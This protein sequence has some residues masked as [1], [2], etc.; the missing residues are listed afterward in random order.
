MNLTKGLKDLLFYIIGFGLILYIVIV[1]SKIDILYY[2]LLI[3]GLFLFILGL[4]DYLRSSSL[5]EIS[6]CLFYLAIIFVGISNFM[7]AHYRYFFSYAAIILAISALLLMSYM[8]V[9]RKQSP[10]NIKSDPFRTALK[11]L[12]FIL[13]PF[14]VII[15]FVWLTTIIIAPSH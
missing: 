11:T 2:I 13:V 1:P 5:W 3:G 4:L 6:S 14:I 15:V 10:K 12:L 7:Y 8:V 9:I